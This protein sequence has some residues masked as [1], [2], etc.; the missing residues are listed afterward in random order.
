MQPNRRPIA[1]LA[2]VFAAPIAMLVGA[3]G[4]SAMSSNPVAST[5]S[6]NGSVLA[7][8]NGSGE[9]VYVGGTFDMVGL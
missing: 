4:A 5:W 1:R 6:V 2:A 3:G 8:A 9:S 7:T